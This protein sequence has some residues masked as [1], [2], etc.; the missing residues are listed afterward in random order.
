MATFKVLCYA[1][2]TENKHHNIQLVT[3]EADSA[4]AA[5]LVAEQSPQLHTKC[6]A[7]NS[8]LDGW[9]WQEVEGGQS[10]TQ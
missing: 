10:A 4:E 3:C 5:K 8:G 2:C 7:C 1:M 9:A 6:Q